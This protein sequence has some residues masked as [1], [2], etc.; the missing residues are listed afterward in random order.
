MSKTNFDK[1]VRWD[2][3]YYNSLSDEDCIVCLTQQEV[4][5]IGQITDMLRWK[6]TRWIG[7]LVGLDLDLIAS[8]LEYKLSE[9]MT[10]QNITKLLEKITQLETKIDYVF[11]ETVVNEGDTVYDVNE[12]V[13]D[14]VY[15]PEQMQSGDMAVSADDCD[16]DGK[17]SIYGAC[18]TLVRYIVQNNID[19]LQNFT[20][21]TGNIAEQIQ[22]LTG[23]FPPTDLLAADD[24]AKYTNFLIDELLEEYEATVDEELIQQTICDLFCIAIANDCVLTMYDVFYYFG[25]KVSPSLSN[26]T[27]TFTDLV[28]FALIGTFT[29]D[30]YFYFLC[31][32]QLLSAGMSD[33]VTG[34]SLQLYEQ[35]MSAGF[36]SP[37]DDWMIFC[38][39]C[40]EIYRKKIWYLDFS[41]DDTQI[42]TGFDLTRGEYIGGS[43][44]GLT[45]AGLPTNGLMTVGL[46]LDSSWVIYGYALRFDNQEEGDNSLTNVALRPTQGT[47]TGAAG[48]SASWGTTGWTYYLNLVTPVTG[49]AEFALRYA[50]QLAETPY[51]R[52]I[53]LIFDINDAPDDAFITENRNFSGEN[54]D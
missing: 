41:Q 9:R 28:Q 11:N 31:Y 51:L 22:T 39:D 18:S 44:Y 13:M 7:N 6:N 49:Y 36:N 24:L 54:F 4:Y 3:D 10:C 30:M 37:D 34:T 45:Q 53:A 26:I 46:D 23:A 19:F 1:L 8:N 17:S 50:A 25:G 52:Q 20:Q 33:V 2:A 14:D 32:F 38:V 48:L 29:G 42:T 40:P 43:G 21:S 16:N 5:L 12:T 27:T 47:N 35:Q 15:T